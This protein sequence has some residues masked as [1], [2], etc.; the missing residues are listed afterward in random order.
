MLITL[1]PSSK[2]PAIQLSPRLLLTGA[3]LFWA[4][5]FIV[6]R[7]LRGDIP[8]VSLNFWRWTTALLILLPLSI[9]Q[10]RRHRALLLQQWKL[11][12]VLGATGVAAFH[13]S[14]YLALTTTP[15]VNALMFLSIAPM[16][17]ALVSWLAF[18]DTI[19]SRQ[20]LGIFISLVGALVVIARGDLSV[21]LALRFNPGDL[22][23]LAAVPLWAVYSVLLKRR[24]AE[25]PQLTL[26]T[27][28]VIAGVGL[29]LPLYLWQLWQLWHGETMVVNAPNLLGLLY[30]AVFA[31]VVAF[32]CW[33]R[34]VAA[35]G[36]TKAGM[37]T[38][39]M[40]VF[41]AVLAVLFLGEPIALYHVLGAVFVLA[42][43]ALTNRGFAHARG[44]VPACV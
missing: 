18:R 7:A 28:T 13:T 15:A 22:W 6:G 2:T 12:L 42:G 14:V 38:Y 40:P 21:L 11:I 39:L 16:V 1:S 44:H 36:P 30:I 31:S 41:G 37:F 34:G 23:M 9:A 3:V 27:A 26:L 10:L 33:N 43:I 20:A 19:T 25:L 35:L 17:I 5:N 32:L 4:G 24:P 8:P 29:L